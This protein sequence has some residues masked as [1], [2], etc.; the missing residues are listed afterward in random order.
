MIAPDVCRHPQELYDIR[1]DLQIVTED[2]D[3]RKGRQRNSD[4][5]KFS[6][7]T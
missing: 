2:G 4:R 1:N 5:E 3:T 7:I 6:P